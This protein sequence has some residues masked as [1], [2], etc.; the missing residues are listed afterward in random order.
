MKPRE[1]KTLPAL[2]ILLCVLLLAIPVSAMENEP[3]GFRGIPWGAVAP[4]RNF[5][6][7]NKWGLEKV[8]TAGDFGNTYFR[9]ESEEVSIGKAKI[10]SP[11]I[12]LFH[13]DYGF[14]AAMIEFEGRA[15]YGHIRQ[16]CIENWGRPDSDGTEKNE[17]FGG[18]TTTSIWLGEKVII[19][20]SSSVSASG[21]GFL[22]LGQSDFVLEHLIE[23]E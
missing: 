9:P 11:V 18:D 3:E 22:I 19:Y 4:E 2:L 12:Y 23:S 13:D 17:K 5:A 16:A 6:E 20:L 1:K 15:D 14:A 7:G 21:T 10:T 8:G